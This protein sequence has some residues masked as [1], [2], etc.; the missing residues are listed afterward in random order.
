MSQQIAGELA[1][2]K[3]R[4]LSIDALRGFD[5]FWIL[6]GEKLFAAFFIITGWSFFHFWAEQMEHSVW[7]GFTAYDLIFPLFIFLSG[8]SLGIGAKPLASYP[9]EKAKAILRHGIKRLA[10]LVLFGV[11]YNH[12]WGRGIPATIDDIRFASVLGRIGISWFVAALLVWY[13]SERTQW[14]AAIGILIGYWLLLQFVTLGGFG[15][16][17]FTA[18]GAINVWFDQHLL[19]GTTYRNLPLDP[20][21]LLS[22]VTSIANALIGVFVGRFMVKEM[23]SPKKLI[24]TLLIVGVS[25]LAAG[26]L[27]GMVFPI[28]KTLWTSSFVL[29]TAGYSV[30]LLTLF[31]LLIDV[32]GLTGWAKFFAVI[33]TNSIIVY[34]GSSLISWK[35]TSTSLFGGLIQ[36]A[37]AGW[38]DVILFGGMLL[39]QWLVLYWLYC[40]KIFIKV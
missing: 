2:K 22:N 20:E 34:L 37:P 13:V 14:I 24:V 39:L 32:I 17:N 15:G 36:V 23:Q 1:P 18:E 35:Y 9:P 25:L 8:V 12:A 27:W 26:Y 7:H 21:G 28:N 16:G 3:K 38:Q 40:R 6:G 10:L 33:G 29:V 4:L 19:P 30:L 31:Y 11:I 5:M